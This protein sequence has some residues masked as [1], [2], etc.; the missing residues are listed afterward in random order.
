MELWVRERNESDGGWIAEVLTQ[1]WG[2][3]AIVTR[4]RL[5]EATRLPA[6]VAVSR[7]S[8]VGLLTARVDADETEIVTLDALEPNRGI[9]TALLD[10]LARW[11]GRR[12]CRRLVLITS[13][14][15]LD[16]LRF[17]QRRGFRVRAV[18]RDAIAQ[19]RVLKPSIPHT[20][21]YGIAV[22]DELELERAI[23]PR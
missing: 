15:N 21:D 7:E 17:Y 8:P 6:L 9:G 20:G 16:A 18:H 3:A 19:A 12:G 1:R 5:H 11:A 22:L 2:G 4:G 14:D 23:E 13:N 10:E